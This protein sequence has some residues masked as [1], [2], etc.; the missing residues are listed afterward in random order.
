[1]TLLWLWWIWM[2]KPVK[3]PSLVK[4]FPTRLCK[5]HWS[6]SFPVVLWGMQIVQTLRSSQRFGT[7]KNMKAESSSISWLPTQKHLD[8]TTSLKI[9]CYSSE[10]KLSF[11]K[12]T[13]VGQGQHISTRTDL[14]QRP[15]QIHLHHLWQCTAAEIQTYTFQCSRPKLTA[16]GSQIRQWAAVC[17]I[18]LKIRNGDLFQRLYKIFQGSQCSLGQAQMENSQWLH[19]IR[20]HLDIW[21][22]LAASYIQLQGV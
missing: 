11:P 19:V 5:N 15:L 1:M 10:G 9:G 16:E 22:V 6:M 17:Y 20:Q 3:L 12:L 2:V 4:L 7:K 18:Q 14:C 21:Q 13:H 8:K